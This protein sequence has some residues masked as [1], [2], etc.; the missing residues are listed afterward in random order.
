M[1]SL[2]RH[3]EYICDVFSKANQVKQR[4]E[5]IT[6]KQFD[7]QKDYCLSSNFYCEEEANDISSVEEC[8]SGLKKKAAHYFNFPCPNFTPTF[9][10]T[11]MCVIQKGL[12]IKKIL[13]LP[14][15]KGAR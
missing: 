9:S 14:N 2:V 1:R 6:C 11:C 3:H 13:T 15:A 5:A 8:A 12:L 7:P 4:H 10:L